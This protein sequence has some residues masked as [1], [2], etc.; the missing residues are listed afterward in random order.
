MSETE[1][2]D[3]VDVARELGRYS[4]D[5]Y[6]FLRQGLDYT[7]REVHGPNVKQVRAVLDWMHHHEV[8]LDSLMELLIK[9]R[10]PSRIVKLI[11]DMGGI[12]EL[13]DGMNLHVSGA[14]LCRG[15]RDL[16][17][18]RWGMMAGTVLRH[19]GIRS[20]RD[21]GEMVF[22]LVEN[23]LLQKQPD[24]V[25]EDFDNVYDFRTAFDRNYRIPV[26]GS[27]EAALEAE[28]A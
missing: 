10:L 18:E 16:A 19:W 24:D 26:C 17:I 23:G 13:A 9:G 22:A 8:D 25:I 7:V 5:A 11:E 21:F 27:T 15:L 6:D 12:E 1:V 28:G 2:K 20:T 3:I 4:P 14:D